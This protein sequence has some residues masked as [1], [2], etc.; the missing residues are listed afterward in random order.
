M[1]VMASAP[2]KTIL[3][4][5]HAVV[6]SQPAIAAAVSKRAIVHIKDSQSNKTI[7]KSEDLGFEAELDTKNKKYILKKGKPGI[8]RYILEALHIAH[9][10]NPIEITLSIDIP[11][12]SGLGSSAAVTVATLAAL[13][14]YHNIYFTKKELAEIA[15]QVEFN[16]QG[17]AS[18]LDTLISTYGGLIYLDRNKELHKINAHINAPFVVGVTSKYGSTSKMV[19]GVKLLKERFPNV[20]DPVIETIG[21]L[22]DEA[23]TAIEKGNINKIGELMNINHG[24]LD[25]IGVNT[26]ELSRMVY[27]A[28]GAG[29][30]GSK[31]TGAG[32]GGS[33]ISLCPG[34][35]DDVSNAIGVYDSTIKLTFSKKGVTSKLIGARNINNYGKNN[36]KNNPNSNYNN[37][38][39]PNNNN[40]NNNNKKYP[41]KYT[42]TNSKK[43]NFVNNNNSSASNSRNIEKRVNNVKSNNNNK[44]KI[45]NNNKDN[46]KFYQN[47]NAQPIKNNRKD[48]AR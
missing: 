42:N 32:G 4:G 9:N 21:D 37:N 23:K 48:Y 44:Y 25:A 35:V 19:K 24:L 28:R 1:E 27:I 30:I 6:Y 47:Q 39:N 26:K 43:S 2:G 16:V 10:H 45:K 18:P 38:N 36:R 8:I 33:I 31:I 5:E 22:T 14:R 20:M 11:I 7:L 34:K 46:K 15:H 17:E 40:N 12:G 41:T 29:A 3:F 13:Y